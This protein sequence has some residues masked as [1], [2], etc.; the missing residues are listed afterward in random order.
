MSRV[1]GPVA[2]QLR[3]YELMI[4]EAVPIEDGVDARTDEGRRA[5]WRQLRSAKAAAPITGRRCLAGV[6]TRIATKPV[7]EWSGWRTRQLRRAPTTFGP[8]PSP[9]L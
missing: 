9:G 2:T 4:V 8:L 6:A 5:P 1:V 7:V 3:R